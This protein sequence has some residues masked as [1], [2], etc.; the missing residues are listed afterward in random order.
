[1]AATATVTAFATKDTKVTKNGNGARMVNGQTAWP[2]S[3]VGSSKNDS[4]AKGL[5]EDTKVTNGNDTSLI[6]K[7][8]SPVPKRTPHSV[9]SLDSLGKWIPPGRSCDCSTWNMRSAVCC[10]QAVAGALLKWDEWLKRPLPSFCRFGPIL[11]NY[12]LFMFNIE[13]LLA[14]TVQKW[15][16]LIS[17]RTRTYVHGHRGEV[18]LT[19]GRLQKFNSL[20]LLVTIGRIMWEGCFVSQYILLVCLTNLQPSVHGRAVP[21]LRSKRG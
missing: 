21:G 19:C 3:F 13:R 2:C 1:M 10:D 20:Y 11:A 18:F 6:A 5:T 12:C 7:S 15:S 8:Q 16:S 4:D 9:W 17:P 14:K